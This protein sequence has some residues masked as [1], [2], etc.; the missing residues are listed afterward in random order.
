MLRDW[1]WEQVLRSMEDDSLEDVGR[2]NSRA[3]RSPRGEVD[4]SGLETSEVSLNSDILRE[5][6]NIDP[7]L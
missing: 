3:G 7:E 6:S 1:A 4:V 5:A 2:L